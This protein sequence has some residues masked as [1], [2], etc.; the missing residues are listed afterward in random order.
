MSYATH[1][2][3]PDAPPPE[4]LAEL[5]AA[6]ALLDRLTARAVELTLDVQESV[7]QVRVAVSDEHGT[8]RLAPSEL[9]DLLAGA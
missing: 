7:R 1:Y 4:L 3:I 2:P 8:R 6:A 5:D 9:L